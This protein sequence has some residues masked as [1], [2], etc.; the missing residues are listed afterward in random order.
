MT[1]PP[2]PSA[3]LPTGDSP[4]AGGFPPPPPQ[5]GFPPPQGGFPPPQ[6]GYPPPPGAYP[7]PPGG[8]PP[9]PGPQGW[10]YPGPPPG[11][12]PPP[13]AG[14]PPP[15]GSFP[16][17]PAGGYPPPPPPQGGYLP[18]PPGFGMR[19][20]YSIGEAFT[21][22][23]N[24]FTKN[25]GPLVVASLAFIVISGA[26]SFLSNALLRAVSPATVTTVDTADG[27]METMTRS[28]TGAGIAVLVLT[29]LVQLVVS[30]AIGSAYFVGVLDIADG[31]PV[32][33]GSFFK[34]RNIVA[35][36]L[37]AL[38]VGVLTT[39]GLVLCILPGLAV[40]VFGWFTTVAIVDRNLSPMDGIR[41]SF[42]LAKANFGT[43]LL[44]WLV[45][46]AI[47]FVGFLACGV[48]LLVAIPV[49]YLFQAYTWRKL[50]G[51]A[52]APAI[53]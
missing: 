18:P 15:P 30:G 4:S 9:P 8:F 5:G 2:D 35:V 45:G 16:P 29:T 43:V 17:P 50:S 22:A 48:G 24:R 40:A 1:Q 33:F 21:W 11:S 34:P 10:G 25:A 28:V 36:V 14:Y 51:G 12:Y 42:A 53:G 44:A 26:F 13:P 6:G 27:V 19:P 38:V 49:S 23:W 31:R 46:L 32:S 52:V 47:E 7:P 39:V 41:A 20:A 37:A 3:G